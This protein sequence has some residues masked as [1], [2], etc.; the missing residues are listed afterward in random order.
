[1][2][3]DSMRGMKLV[4]ALCALVGL[5]TVAVTLAFGRASVPAPRTAAA[6]SPGGPGATE[7]YGKRLI[8]QTSEYLGPDVPNASMRSMD[9]RLACASCHIGAGLEP[10]N[11]S[12]ATAF[13]RYPRISPRSG[14][15]E[16]IQDRINGCMM[17]SMNGRA[18]AED[19]PEMVAMVA[20]LRFLSSQDAETGAAQKKAHEP[21]AFK[22]PNRA[23]H[24]KNGEQVFS[25]R[26]AACHGAEGAGLAA[27][28]DLI[29]GFV[30]PPLWGPNSFNDGAGMHRVLTAAKFVKARMPLG[31]PD[32]NDDQAFDVA[33]YLNSRPRPHKEGLEQ[34]FPDRAKK[35]IDTGYGPYADPFSVEQHTFGPFAPIEAFY[36]NAQKPAK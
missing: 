4:M 5:V 32:L 23:A 3:P 21:A 11:L 22:T 16:T 36:K 25:Q 2:K 1:M 7:E 31:N 26:C 18:L 13:T 17:R 33:A 29:H 9:S 28:R 34:D 35:P 6:T 19:S 24:L 10:G 30:F 14:G 27:A 20:Y 8:A 15:N 12:L